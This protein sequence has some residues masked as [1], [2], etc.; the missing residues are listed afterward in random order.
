MATATQVILQGPAVRR[1]VS[2]QPGVKFNSGFFSLSS[3]AFFQIT[4]SVIFRAS[5]HQLVDEKK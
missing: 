2:A 1:P 5:N 4:F 3:K